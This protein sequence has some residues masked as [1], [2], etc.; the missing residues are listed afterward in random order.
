MSCRSSFVELSTSSFSVNSSRSLRSSASNSSFISTKNRIIKIS[1]ELLLTCQTNPAENA[2]IYNLP[3]YINSI[4]QVNSTIFIYFYESILG[5]CLSE[6]KF[7][8]KSTEDEIHN[9]Q[10]V[11]D[12]I[13]LDVL[14]EDLSHIQAA[15]ICCQS[16]DLLSVEYLLDIMKSIQEWISS[17]LESIS[18]FS[19]TRTSKISQI[20]PIKASNKSSNK[21]GKTKDRN[22]SKERSTTLVSSLNS[23]TAF[24]NSNFKSLHNPMKESNAKEFKKIP[25]FDSIKSSSTPRS[26]FRSLSKDKS[27]CK[28][29]TPRRTISLS[30][31][32]SPANRSI[33]KSDI[34]MESIISSIKNDTS[35]QCLDQIMKKYSKQIQWIEKVKNL[36]SNELK[37]EKYVNEAY[38]KQ[39]LL[40]EII[41][42]EITLNQRLENLKRTKEEK[43][44]QKAKQRESRIEKARVKK[45]I[46]DLKA[47]EKSSS[48]RQKLNEEL[49]L[50]KKFD[51]T[52]RIKKETLI[53]L[54]KYNRDKSEE[55]LVRQLNEIDSM[56]NFY[57][58]RFELLNEQLKKE[59]ELSRQRESSQ[60][61][62][63]SK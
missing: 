43:L 3:K 11:I 10:L 45:Y 28:N 35:S 26:M 13:S 44:C 31:S 51:E 58:T 23:E 34:G 59:R 56:E 46:D 53:D 14:H 24:N 1:N 52:L 2:Q 6:K 19:S 57:K 30:F 18:S 20:T 22:F 36:N 37:F 7:P 4:N 48:L 38:N 21:L 15:A 42:K 16:P 9:V 50:K 47:K 63:V 33:N 17:R 29:T 40:V 12:S 39:K 32:K 55:R 41:K 5:T 60:K 62:L 61:K 8:P 25:N 54:K 49:Q 27:V